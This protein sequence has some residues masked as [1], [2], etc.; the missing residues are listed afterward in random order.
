MLNVSR[1]KILNTE[2]RTKLQ[3][4]VTWKNKDL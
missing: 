4:D 3:D 1:I 2:A